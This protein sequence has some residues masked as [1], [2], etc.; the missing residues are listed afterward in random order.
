M[1]SV[2]RRNNRVFNGILIQ[3][4]SN[5]LEHEGCG[6]WQ[7]FLNSPDPHISLWVLLLSQ[8]SAW[9]GFRATWGSPVSPGQLLRRLRG[10]RESL[11]P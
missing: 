7:L 9:H 6:L 11:P 3:A 1:T 4:E 8:Q 2:E 5:L 10:S